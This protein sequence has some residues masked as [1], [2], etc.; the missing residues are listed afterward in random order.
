VTDERVRVGDVLTLERRPVAI[1]PMREYELLGAYSWGKGLFR[2]EPKSGTEVGSFRFFALEPADLVLSNIQAWEGAIGVAD[3]ADCAAIATHRFLT[4]VPADDRINT[5][6]AKWF[7]L[8]EPGMA[9]IRMAS[10]GTTM[11]NRTLAI[12]RFEALEIPLP[13][14]EAQLRVASRVDG[15]DIAATQLH[16]GIDRAAKLSDALG[17][18]IAARTD[19]PEAV[20]QRAGWQRTR[21]GRVLEPASEKVRVEAGVVYPNV[22]VFSFGRG[23]F[24]KSPIDGSR[25][26]ATVLNRIHAGQF[27]Y[28]RLFAFE[29]AYTFVRPEFDG[30]FVSNEFPSFNVD[31]GRLDVRWL[32]TFLRSPDRWSELGGRSKGLGV[33][34]QRVPVEAVLDFEVWLP[35]IETQREMVDAIDRVAQVELHRSA[36]EERINALVPAALNE[37]FAGVS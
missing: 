4:Y 17:V 27:I 3:V 24:E 10:P 26:A 1:D 2:R 15:V 23:L 30:F 22:G 21:L 14:I 31:E 18:S 5:T 6:W 11:R 25:T 13:P 12:D 33:R 34:R 32:A 16:Q 37:A 28:S 7:F 8:S 20:R 35:P 9:L 36:I 19:I 29:G